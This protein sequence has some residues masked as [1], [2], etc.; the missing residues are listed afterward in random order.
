MR[1]H[2]TRLV[3][4]L[5]LATVVLADGVR[6]N[7]Q[8]NADE[9]RGFIV[10]L[11]SR[12]V[13]REEVAVVR[14]ADG[15][16]VRGSSRLGPPLN[17][18]T[19]S[20]EIRYT[21]AWQPTKLTVE[22]TS[23]GQEVSI[24]TSFADGKAETT[25]T[26]DGK[27][28][29]DS[30]EVAAD[31]IVLP[32]AFLGSYAALARRLAG[33]QSGQAFRA[34][35]A[36][37]SEVSI[38][39]TGVSE[40]RI[41]TPQRA[42]NAS[43]YALL[44]SQPGG[45]IAAT[46]WADREGALLRLSVPMQSLELAREDVASASSR[47]TSFSLPTDE[48]VRIPANGFNL[49]GS[50]AKPAGAAGE[51]PAVVLLSGSGPLDR[52]S[53][54]AGI[55]IM[56]QIAGALVDAGF[57][58]VRYDKRGIG[59]SGGR[60]ESA[61]ILDYVDDARAVV[62]WLEKRRD[63]DEDRI[64]VVGHSEGGWVALAAAA[65]EKKIRAVAIL[66]APATP[67]GQVVLEQQAELFERMKT[68]EAERQEKVDLQKRINAAV[69]GEGSWEGI[70]EDLR[71]SAESPWFHSYLSFDPARYMKDVRQPILI[72]QGELDTQVAPHHADKLA[73]LAR[74]RKRNVP[75]ELVKVPGVNHLLVPA[76]TGALDEYASLSKEQ[77]SSA[78]T[79]AISLWLAK[80]LGPGKQITRR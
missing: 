33:A 61:T 45:E 7:A 15:W 67:G 39:V 38:Q 73:E 47:T 17:V 54:V 41:E 70:P 58:V 79:S 75:V 72:V 77:V 12:P 13:G 9:S 80:S 10:F 78:V 5:T 6:V 19:R 31:T 29:T 11:Q 62:K 53:T 48:P 60:A 34:Y 40:D 68:P 26:V 49:A 42:I 21:E 57:L 20:A 18:V 27:Q 76:K 56:G 2:C 35:I 71:K 32:N 30:D 23:R 8:A 22:G 69:L 66:A 52:D 25:V 3:A 55:P 28:E 46:L 44:V 36:P 74:A 50:V 65:R 4:T 14:D 64:A 43:R 51:L 1:S 37:Q 16:V 24:A 63:V 59:Q